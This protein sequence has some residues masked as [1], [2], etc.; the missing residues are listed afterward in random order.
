MSAMW[1]RLDD[2]L[3]DNPKMLAL[4]HQE[5]RAFLLWGFGL[6]WCGRHLT[7]G[8]LPE[9]LLPRLVP[10]SPEDL[11]RLAGVLVKVGLWEPVV[12]GFQYHDY[13][14]HAYPVDSECPSRREPGQEPQEPRADLCKA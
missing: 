8:F 6:S 1:N 10:W 11:S 5:A 2:S 7:D 4:V 12:G 14:D 13:L 9:A 3:H